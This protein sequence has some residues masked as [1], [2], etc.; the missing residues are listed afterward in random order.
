MQRKPRALGFVF[1][2]EPIR[3]CLTTAPNPV[4]FTYQAPIAKEV[5]HNL[6]AIEAELVGL[7]LDMVRSV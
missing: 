5:G 1:G 4:P 7:W 2:V 6:H 3:M